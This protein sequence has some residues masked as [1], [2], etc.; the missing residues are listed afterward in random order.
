MG[1][2]NSAAMPSVSA[3][4]VCEPPATITSSSG[5]SEAS[6]SHSCSS[7]IRDSLALSASVDRAM[8]TSV[9]RAQLQKIEYEPAPPDFH[10]NVAETLKSKY[11]VL[12]ANG[13]NILNGSGTPAKSA[14]MGATRKCR[15]R[16]RRYDSDPMLCYIVQVCVCVVA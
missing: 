8:L 16:C 14:G 5:S 7:A 11:T 10:N 15:D 6:A 9:K 1:P 13:P 12:N 2:N 3:S 4:V